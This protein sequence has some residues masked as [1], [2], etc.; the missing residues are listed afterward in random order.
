MQALHADGSGWSTRCLVRPIDWNAP[1]ASLR[2]G[3]F[4]HCGS[5]AKES[6]YN[7]GDPALIPGLGRSLEKTM[8]THS[9]ILAQRMPWTEEHDRATNTLIHIIS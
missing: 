3:G 6:A 8:A 7:V 1:L 2:S 5:D 9:Y 4:P